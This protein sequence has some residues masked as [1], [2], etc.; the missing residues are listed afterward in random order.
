MISQEVHCTDI[1][2][3]LGIRILGGGLEFFV[4]NI[5][6]EKMGE[7]NK[8]PQLRHGGN[9]DYHDLKK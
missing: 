4:I 2:T 3:K 8:R 1:V 5:F 7:I 9:T 6:V